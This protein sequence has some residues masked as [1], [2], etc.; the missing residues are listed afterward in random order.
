MEM[1]KNALLYNR[2]V[3]CSTI[4]ILGILKI[5]MYV[6]KHACS[7]LFFSTIHT[8]AHVFIHIYTYGNTKG[9]SIL[10]LSKWKQETRR[11]KSCPA[12]NMCILIS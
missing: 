1:A 6:I 8:C 4:F 11:A 2:L 7:F 9:I 3:F 12:K 10:K 5:F